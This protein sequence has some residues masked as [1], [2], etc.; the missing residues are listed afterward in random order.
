VSETSETVR[1]LSDDGQSRHRDELDQRVRALNAER[2]RPV[3]PPPVAP[4]MA[5]LI[6]ALHALYY[7]SPDPP[8]S[9]EGAA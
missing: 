9:Q 3:A 4:L 2:Q 6:G 7:T 8:P 5:Q 1:T